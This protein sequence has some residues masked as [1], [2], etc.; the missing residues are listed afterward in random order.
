MTDSQ[1]ENPEQETSAA[2]QPEPEA[3]PQAAVT[4]PQ[5]GP[6]P[7][8]TPEPT[9]QAA[10]A[11]PQP[12]PEPTAQPAV[13][14][15]QA[16]PTPE[17]S[18][19]R[20]TQEVSAVSPHK[21]ETAEVQAVPEN[22][23]LL[24]PENEAIV[25]GASREL[26]PLGVRWVFILGIPLLI[27]AIGLCGYAVSRWLTII[28]A[29]PDG[30]NT[31]PDTVWNGTLWTLV[32][33]LFAAIVIGWYL[34]GLTMVRKR[35][36]LQ[37]R[38]QLVWGE[39]IAAVGKRERSGDLSVTVEYQFTPP[40]RRRRRPKPIHNEDAETRNDLKGKAL[41]TPETPVVLLY[42]N[43]KNYELL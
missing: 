30:T 23:F 13:V 15:P 35:G 8:A 12:E 37:K 16:E 42:L 21:T 31:P 14:T 34:S 43:D 25:S 27:A 7:Q 19:S 32:A 40:T 5:P 3:T 6:T 11:A 33:F 1:P 29:I 10:V 17:T 9:P 22:Y 39:V 28:P 2:P 4:A 20:A 18:N 24:H 36:S 41:P 38:G 26:P